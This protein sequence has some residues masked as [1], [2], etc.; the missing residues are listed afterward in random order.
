[1]CA[2]LFSLSFEADVKRHPRKCAHT[3]K[4]Y[5]GVCF[6]SHEQDVVRRKEMIE[7]GNHGVPVQTRQDWRLQGRK[8]TLSAV[9][10]I[11]LADSS[12]LHMPQCAEPGATKAVAHFFVGPVRLE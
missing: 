11:V 6:Q 1:M 5:T 10:S 9:K 3:V 2:G 12:C 7:E 8:N 4:Q